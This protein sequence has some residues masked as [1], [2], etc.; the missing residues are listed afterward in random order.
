[1][2]PS[3]K[4]LIIEDLLQ[5]NLTVSNFYTGEPIDLLRS[6]RSSVAEPYFAFIPK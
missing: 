2:L 5:K 3:S 4:I 6:R 1:M